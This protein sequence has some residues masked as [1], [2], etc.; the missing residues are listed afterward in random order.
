MDIACR[1]QLRPRGDRSDHGQ[2]ALIGH[3]HLARPHRRADDLGLGRSRWDGGRRGAGIAGQRGI[4]AG[5]HGN[6]PQV[7]KQ[8]RVKSGGILDA[9]HPQFTLAQTVQQGADTVRFLEA[10][11]LAQIQHHR[12]AGK[13]LRRAAQLFIQLRMEAVVGHVA[14]DPKRQNGQEA[15][16]NLERGCLGRGPVMPGTGVSF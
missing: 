8:S 5:V 9:E 1:D 15:A 11:G 10:R 3:D 16:A 4:A 6:Q 13:E 14:V 2:V 12:C 7:V